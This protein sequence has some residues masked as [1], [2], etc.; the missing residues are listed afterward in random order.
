[1]ILLIISNTGNIS[2]ALNEA[3]RGLIINNFH[4]FD[5]L[6]FTECFLTPNII[7]LQSLLMVCVSLGSGQKEQQ[8]S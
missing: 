2:V 8:I 3:N 4:L 7:L 6:E 5:S 1:M